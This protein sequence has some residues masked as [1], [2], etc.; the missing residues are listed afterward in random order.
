M[1]FPEAYDT[2]RWLANKFPDKSQAEGV[3]ARKVA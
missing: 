2:I 1:A 3:W